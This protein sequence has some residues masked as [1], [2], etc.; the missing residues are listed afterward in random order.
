MGD[1][2]VVLIERGDETIIPGETFC[3]GR[4]TYLF[5]AAR[6]IAETPIRFWMN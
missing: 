1:V 2:L 3:F 4:E 6:H 5:S